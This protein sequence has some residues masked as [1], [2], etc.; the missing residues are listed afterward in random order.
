M[1]VERE[2]YVETV[3]GDNSITIEKTNQRLTDKGKAKLQAK[4]RLGSH[5]LNPSNEPQTVVR[6]KKTKEDLDDIQVVWE[7]TPGRCIN[8]RDHKSRKRP[9]SQEPELSEVNPIDCPKCGMTFSHVEIVKMHIGGKQCVKRAESQR[10]QN[11]RRKP[12]G[13]KERKDYK[14]KI[15]NSS[16]GGMMTKGEIRTAL[17][18]RYPE[19]PAAKYNTL[20]GPVRAPDKSKHIE[21]A[22]DMMNEMN[23]TND[24]ELCDLLLALS[25]GHLEA[26]D[27]IRDSKEMKAPQEKRTA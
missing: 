24:K 13:P 12:M 6:N 26:H 7:N 18:R 3:H 10:D 22:L 27:L 19:I 5:K 8:C 1:E 15:K 17:Q 14:G 2:I 9:A 16:R 4:Y 21:L 20:I 23:G 11:E 25:R